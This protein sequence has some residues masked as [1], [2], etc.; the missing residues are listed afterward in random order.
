VVPA[1][2]PGWAADVAAA[3]AAGDAADRRDK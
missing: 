3:A 2:V 1:A